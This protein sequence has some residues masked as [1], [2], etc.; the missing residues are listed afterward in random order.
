MPEERRGE[1]RGRQLHMGAE[2]ADTITCASKTDRPIL[3]ELI[4][5]D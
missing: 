2:E 4:Q 3:T 5:E 1:G